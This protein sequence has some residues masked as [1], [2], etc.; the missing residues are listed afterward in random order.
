MTPAHTAPDRSVNMVFLDIGG[1]LY[2]DE[3]Y[4]NS[5]TEALRELGAEFTDEEFDAEYSACRR[6]QAGSFRRRL[7]E[8][9]L[10]TSTKAGQ[11]ELL[12]SKHW[13]YHPA[14][15]YPDA[16]PTLEQLHGRYRLG[17]LANQPSA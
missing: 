14:D 4:R 16:R 6:D 8:R 17:I 7:S 10:G 11:V 13:R 12:A 2:S 15:L 5:L 3:R 1:V 9:F